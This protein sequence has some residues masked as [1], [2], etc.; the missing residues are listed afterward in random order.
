VATLSPLLHRLYVRYRTYRRR[1][2][3][4]SALSALQQGSQVVRQIGRDT[5]GAHEK[6]QAP[7][8]VEHVALAAVV[9]AVAFA[10]LALLEVDL[11][12][13]RRALRRRHVAVKSQKARIE[14][15]DVFRQQLLRI[16][17]RIDGDEQHLHALRI[18]S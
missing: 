5:V 2:T 14:G 6:P 7:L 10:G 18:R 16:A 8:R 1:D 13:P 12:F 17:L 9:D 11:E 15:G 3:D 4:G